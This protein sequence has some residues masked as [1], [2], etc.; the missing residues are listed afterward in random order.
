MSAKRKPPGWRKALA[1]VSTTVEVRAT[2][3]ADPCVSGERYG[4]DS[5]DM[6][7]DF[8]CS[9]E[10]VVEWALGDGWTYDKNGNWKCPD[11]SYGQGFGRARGQVIQNGGQPAR[12][13]CRLG[14][15]ATRPVDCR[16]VAER[17]C[18]SNQTLGHDSPRLAFALDIQ[19]EGWTWDKDGNWLCP[20][21][22]KVGE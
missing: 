12:V 4:D 21:C 16:I 14:T 22:S 19:Q 17:E 8:N 18:G 7:V 20:V 11:C 2:C 3:T 15:W 5:H 13:Q 10:D 9:K 1:E 6:G